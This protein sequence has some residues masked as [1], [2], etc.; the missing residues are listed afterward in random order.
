[1]FDA[2][3][4]RIA[5]FALVSLAFAC[6][7]AP[8]NAALPSV[9]DPGTQPVQPAPSTAGAHFGE[10]IVNAG[11]LDGDGE[12]DIIIGAPDF[13]DAALGSGITGRVYAM[14]ASGI[15]IWE[16][17][18]PAPQASHAGR[19]TEFGTRVARLGDIGKG[20]CSTSCTLDPTGDGK[21]EILVGAPG[22]DL[23]NTRVDA[24]VVYV[25][26]GATGFVLKEVRVAQPAGA[27]LGDAIASFSGQPP[28]SAAGGIGPCAN[29][30]SSKVTIGDVDG[31]GLP[32]FAVG[33]PGFTEF[34]EDN[35][36]PPA[37]ACPD[38]GR[39]FAVFG[40][41]ITGSSLSPLEEPGT[42]LK[43]PGSLGGGDSPRFGTAIAP[44]GDVGTCGTGSVPPNC[45]L[46]PPDGW[47]DLMISAPGDDAQSVD[48]AGVA[49][50]VDARGNG[51]MARLTDPL[52]VPSGAFGSFD[53]SSPAVGNLG[54]DAAPDV[55]VGTKK[56]AGAVTTFS[57]NIATSSP[58]VSFTDPAPAAGGAFGA[59]IAGIGDI[60]G[61]TPA[62]VAIG[63]AGGGRAGSVHI[64]SACA[65]TILRTIGPP[66]GDSATGFGASIAAI[67]D[68]NNDSFVELAVGAPGSNGG[69]GYVYVFTST[70]PADT[71]FAGCGGSTGGG[72]PTGSGT[73]TPPKVRA[74]VLRRLT[75]RPSKRR[76]K[77]GTLVRFAGSLKAS[78][79]QP[80]CQRRQKIAIQR[81]KLSGGRFQTFDVA[82]TARNGS[83]R[84][85][86]RPSRS[87]VYRARV[88][89]TAGCMGATSNRAKVVV[90]RA[91]KA[92]RTRR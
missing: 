5:G 88:A 10:S 18:A 34:D 47:P 50:V 59:A 73:T 8:A 80:A 65:R 9:W 14:R 7:A 16:A 56:D 20:V 79:G 90:R 12:D 22:T 15:L 19:S 37:A 44:L 89:Q 1:M 67:G 46:E 91:S 69:A 76:L 57:G 66:A 32:D 33:A 48:D 83:F 17:T 71:S 29:S 51:A 85:S 2:T 31:G 92:A 58:I 54:S 28:C 75:M 61:D 11:D 3:R 52:P 49:Y 74:R 62:E 53:Q 42:E 55:A 6:A 41:Q 40:E 82:V 38:I 27:N 78:A 72:G 86:F 26:D 13:A 4:F 24:G 23:G 30:P 43:F 63:A 81:R 84:A 60:A 35:V 68:Q 21:S 87:F 77:R 64:A 36:C 45:Q 39:A 25:L 70:G